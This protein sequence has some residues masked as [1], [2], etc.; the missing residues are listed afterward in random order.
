LSSIQWACVAMLLYY[1]PDVHRWCR[2]AVTPTSP[3][4]ESLSQS[5]ETT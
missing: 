3:A 1:S 4:V 5:E 2:A